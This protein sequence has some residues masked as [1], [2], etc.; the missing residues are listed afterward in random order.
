MK[1]R[2]LLCLLLLCSTVPAQKLDKSRTKKIVRQR[3]VELNLTYPALLLKPRGTPRGL[4]I[5]NHAATQNERQIIDLPQFD[6]LARTLNAAGYML[7]ASSHGD[8]T[9]GFNWGN[10]RALDANEELYRY[11][12][13]HYQ[14][15]VERVGMIG[16]SMGG[17]IT[18]TAI[19][20]GRIPVRCAAL[21]YP[22]TAL[23]AVYAY[24]LGVAAAVNFAYGI[25]HASEYAERT[26][27][28]DPMLRPASD[29]KG[30]GLRVYGGPGDRI[31]PWWMNAEAFVNHVKGEA[32]EVEIVPLEGNHNENVETT[33]R[34]LVQFFDRCF[35]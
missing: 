8:P 5:F 19:P 31:V 18:L 9:A 14:V 23:G 34:D 24:S 30:A 33:G 25:W 17:L 22:V 27:G 20:E 7:A 2:F 10:R 28:H 6:L 16:N 35:G 1:I 4:I 29:W 11:I 32:K 12:V 13:A 15:D 21:Y 3:V 26:R